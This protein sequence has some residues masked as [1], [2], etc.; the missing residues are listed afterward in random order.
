MKDLYSENYKTL[1]EEIEDDT[2]KWKDILCFWIGRINIVKMVI[3]PKAICRFNAIPIK[4][5]RTFFKELREI[6][7]KFIWNHKRPRIAKAVVRKKNKAG[8]ISL[9]D[10]RLNY[11]ATV[12]TTTWYWHKTRHI[13]Q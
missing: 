4:T 9:P 6:V 2:K 12:I 3:V 11:K 8:G 10:F 13:N 7:L 5:P 1:M